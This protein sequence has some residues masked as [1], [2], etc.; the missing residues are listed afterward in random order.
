MHRAHPRCSEDA[1]S[2]GS[3]GFI[4]FFSSLF[5]FEGQFSVLRHFCFL[6]VPLMEICVHNDAAGTKRG[7]VAESA[8][9]APADHFPWRQTW[10]ISGSALRLEESPSSRSWGGHEPPRERGFLPSQP[11]C[12][13]PSLVD[14]GDQ[15]DGGQCLAPICHS[16]GGNQCGVNS[17]V[18]SQVS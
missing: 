5:P 1:P 17:Q 13:L 3:Q 9:G 11:P 16:V 7:N 2:Q 18:R 8:P 6:P 12:P 4:S 14:Q 10:R 15:R